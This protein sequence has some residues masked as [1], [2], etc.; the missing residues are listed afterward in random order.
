[1]DD[2]GL[3]LNDIE[4]IL[5]DG[6]KNWFNG[7]MS[8]AKNSDVVL[9]T[10][11]DTDIRHVSH[12]IYEDYWHV[13]NQMEDS[14]GLDDHKLAAIFAIRLLDLNTPKWLYSI[15]A[16]STSKPKR[17]Q[18]VRIDMAMEVFF[19]IIKSDR[20]GIDEKVEASLRETFKLNTQV[21]VF[22]LALIAFFLEQCFSDNS[23][24]VED[25]Q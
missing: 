8:G 12:L 18:K 6:V 25:Q 14:N 15:K 17:E 21:S 13:L 9:S 23:D 19:S 7:R 10:K 1:M 2:D 4:S 20:D 11:F 24:E 16:T 22:S 5:R 3:T